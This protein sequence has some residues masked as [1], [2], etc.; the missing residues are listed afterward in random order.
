MIATLGLG[1]V[2]VIAG[3]CALGLACV[4]LIRHM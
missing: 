3:I 1:A 4:W 2:L